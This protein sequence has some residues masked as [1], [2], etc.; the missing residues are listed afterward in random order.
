MTRDDYVALLR[1]ALSTP[2]GV[3][4]EFGNHGTAEWARGRLY[5][6]R[7]ILRRS[8]DTSFD[9]LSFIRQPNGDLWIVRRDQL[10]SHSME[11]GISGRTRSIGRDELPDHFGYCNVSF[12]VSTPKVSPPK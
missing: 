9:S 2:H 8:G 3:A 12:A 7:R 1:D 6:L 10:T 11:D 5:R 4:L